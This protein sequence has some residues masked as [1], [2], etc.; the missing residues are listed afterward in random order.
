MS[1]ERLVFDVVRFKAH[2]SDL[3][4]TGCA[5]SCLSSASRTHAWRGESE[6]SARPSRTSPH[7]R[8]TLLERHR[9]RT[10]LRPERSAPVD[11]F[12]L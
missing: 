5:E 4:I 11:R 12:G 2:S 8:D 1:P 3:M 7:V 9:R 6:E 10:D